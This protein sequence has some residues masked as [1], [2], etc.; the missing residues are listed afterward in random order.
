M[1]GRMYE[2]TVAV[3][4]PAVFN[5]I[6]FFQPFA[7]EAIFARGSEIGQH[8]GSHLLVPLV[9]IHISGSAD[10]TEDGPLNYHLRKR[11]WG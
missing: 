11:W 10:N 2:G 8:G 5:D 4:L 3:K 1:R 7:A 6:F 9:G